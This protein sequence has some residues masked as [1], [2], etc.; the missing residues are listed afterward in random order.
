[1]QIAA[2]AVLLDVEGTTSSVS[3]VYERMFPYARRQLPAYLDAH[4]NTEECQAA[5]DQIARDAGYADLTD[6]AAQGDPRALV[7]AEVIRLMDADEKATGLKQLQGL[8]W[9]TGFES[10]ELV[11]HVYPDTPDALRAWRQQGLDLRVYSSGSVAAQRLFFGHTEYGDLLPLLSGHYDTKTGP[12]RE[13][14][15]Y[16]RIAADWGVPPTDVLFL[17]DIAAELDAA[18]TAGMQTVLLL[19]PGNAPQPAGH[20]H[21]E[22]ADFSKLELTIH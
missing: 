8:I 6:W 16:R 3:F 20:G 5:C 14:D 15:S 18:R 11:A 1:M 10:G 4:L 22:A 9:R 2:R 19:R 21:P 12:K 13:A 17:S 7:E